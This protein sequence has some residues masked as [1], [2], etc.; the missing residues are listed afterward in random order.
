V[1]QTNSLSPSRYLLGFP[2]RTRFRVLGVAGFALA[3]A[4]AAQI[5]IPLPGT[6]VPVTLQTL[7]VTLAP[8]ALGAGGGVAAMSLYALLGLAGL[9]VFADGSGGLHVAGGAT[10]GYILGFIACQPVIALIAGEP[11]PRRPGVVRSLVALVLG[12]AVV[13]GL[14]LAWLGVWLA[15]NDRASGLVTVL[16]MGLFPFLI[17]MLL[18]GA[19]AGAIGPDLSLW[20]ARRGG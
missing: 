17:G 13:F 5:A 12:Y 15:V 6:P 18:K 9:P 11:G 2:E 8:F 1:T 3:T 20:A 10:M 16:E 4:V 14:G 19:L 7:V